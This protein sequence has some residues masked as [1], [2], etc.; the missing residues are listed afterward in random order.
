MTDKELY[1]ERE[2]L[3]ITLTS[4]GDAVITTDG[5]ARVTFLNPVA[6]ALTG[7]TLAEASGLPLTTIFHI[8]NEETRHE[9]ENPVQRALREGVVVG[10]ANHTLLIAK[11]GSE[12]PI[13]DSAAPIRSDDSEVIGVVLVF[14]DITERRQAEEALRQSEERCRLLIEAVR[15]YAIFMLDPQGHVTSWNTGAQHIKGYA[16]HEIIGKHF[17][18]FYP[19]EAIASHWPEQELE[20]ATAEGRFEDEGWRLRKDGSKFWA[21]VIITALRNPFGKL[22][23]F[24]KITRDLTERRQLERAQV[25]AEMMADLNRRKDEFLAMLSHELRNPLSPILNAVHLLDVSKADSALQEQARSII[26]RQVGH[27]TRLIDDLLEVSRITTGKIQIHREPID[28]KAVVEHGLEAIKPLAEQRQHTLAVDLPDELVRL[29]GDPTRLEQV[30]VNVL[31]NAI[32]YTPEGG[33]IWLT[34]ERTPTQAVLRVRDTGVGIPADLLSGVFDLFTQGQRSIDRSEGGLGVGLTI[35]K[36]VVEMH[37]GRVEAQSAGAGQGSEFVLTLPLNTENSVAQSSPTP[38]ATQEQRPALRILVVDDNQDAADTTAMLLRVLGHDVR[39]AYNGADGLSAA[40]DAV[41]D[42]ALL[43][44][45]LPGM[46]G[47][48]LARRLR[49]DQRL[50]N[51]ALVAITGYGRDSDRELSNAAG[52]DAHLVKPVDMHKL[53]QVLTTITRRQRD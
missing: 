15:D 2:R 46:D 50:R 26:G 25:E 27:L 34:L 49:S 35:V 52:F 40:F 23:G 16:A 36:Q 33:Q 1:E 6:E 30:V 39:V 43:D 17:S 8:V 28:L 38:G 29:D 53:E 14:R 44:I 51:I 48:E 22:I 13:D 42:T 5:D 12:R 47:Y 11:D 19:P 18:T 20:M 32:K 21:N 3:R 41:P 10:L 37:G 9:V 45:G 7:W 24:S 4:I 31:T